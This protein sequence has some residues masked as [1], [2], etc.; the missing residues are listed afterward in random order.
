MKARIYQIHVDRDEN[1][2]RH[3]KLDDL[4]KYQGSSKV[5]EALYDRVFKAEVDCSDL[6]QLFSLINGS[7]HPLYHG[8]EMKVS[9]VVVTEEGAFYCDRFGFVEI[10][11]DE[12]K[13]VVPECL[14]RVLYVEPGKAPY[15]TEIPDMLE[16]EQQAV[17][18]PMELVHLDRRTLLICNEEA[19]FERKPGNRRLDN[20]SVIA[21]PFLIVGDGGSTFCSLSDEQ[22][23]RY[24]EKFKE[25]HEISQDEVQADMGMY[26][27]PL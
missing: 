18:G 16:Y 7:G 21:G 1:R 2:V 6:E 13:A 8:G 26:F 22:A 9:D 25:P 14:M 24:M 27:I 11:F 12:A 10:D 3:L 5:N 17:Q 23:D 4:A 20:G 15:E 19:K